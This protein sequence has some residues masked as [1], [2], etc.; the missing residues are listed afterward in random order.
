MTLK[1]AQMVKYVIF[2]KT[3]TLTQGKASFPTAK[4]FTGMDRGGFLKLVA[5]AEVG[6]DKNA[7]WLHII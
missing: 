6:F 3:G 2:D 4:V 7:W 5:S 1:R